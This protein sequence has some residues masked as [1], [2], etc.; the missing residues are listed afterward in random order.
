M[1][2]I[3]RIHLAQV[4]YN[5]ELTA[6][7]ELEKYLAAI[8]R[9][10]GTDADSLREIEARMGELLTE[11]GVT[12][13]K[14]ITMQDVAQLKTR[15]GEPGEFASE[16]NLATD[17]KKRFMRD[18]R[19]G[20]LG[21]VLA[22]LSAYTGVDVVWYRIAA[23]ILAFVSF[24][25]AL[26]LYVV[27]WIVVPP[28]RTAAERLQ[29]RGDEP[30]LENIQEE[31]AHMG[32]ERPTRS[33]PF[34]VCIRI[35]GALSFVGAA[36]G[37]LALVA[38]ALGVSIPMFGQYDWLMNRWLMGSLIG[39]ALSGILFAVLMG[40]CGYGIGAW[41]INKPMSTALAVVTVVGFASFGISV[42]VGVYGGQ[43]LRDQ[44]ESH[45]KVVRTPA[46]QLK[47]VQEVHIKN[48]G[49][50]MMATRY[51]VTTGDPYIEARILQRDGAR[52]VPIEIVRNGNAATI[53][54]QKTEDTAHCYGLWN[55]SMGSVQ[56]VTIY[57]PAVGILRADEGSV[58]YETKQ[59]GLRVDVAR[60]AS[61]VLE[62]TLG[63]IEGSVA[64]NGNLT[65]SD[66]AVDR[67]NLTVDQ[68]SGVQFG[69]VQ[70][71]EFS[72]P[73][74]CGVNTKSHVSYTQAKEVT[75][76]GAVHTDTDVSQLVC[77]VLK[78]DDDSDPS[79]MVY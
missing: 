71:L 52:R 45:T 1:K 48:A 55:C 72:A 78:R 60:N 34:I 49:A 63:A 15:L 58:R 7:K 9:Q 13:E 16:P 18:S 47:G 19:R 4:P 51:V 24:G 27:L 3:T 53:S 33:K 21:G 23:I 57:G 36:V 79:R 68:G 50:P 25:T 12:N 5:I 77:L 42:G 40:L 29:M 66:A 26:L 74:S 64:T 17:T 8:E 65:A 41:R 44:I 59:A 70:S 6:K 32:V 22:G 39:M 76:N 69:V 43:Q 30:S 14:V 20:M 54:Q 67:V 11:R 61:L 46:G 62:G 37:A 31:A 38:F 73:T 2:E 28:A 10:L 75:V 56:E 35:L